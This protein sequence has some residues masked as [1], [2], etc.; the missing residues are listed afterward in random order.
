MRWM[1]RLNCSSVV[2]FD[3]CIFGCPK[4]KPTTLLLIRLPRLR[5]FILSQGNRGRCPHESGTRVALQGC[6]DQG[7]FKTSVAKIY[8][9]KMNAAIA[10][11]TVQFLHRTFDLPRQTEALSED[12][13][14]LMRSDFVSKAVVQPDCYLD[15]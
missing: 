15:V 1:R 2:T 9:A 13:V 5:D 6:D 12:L 10:D 8:P 7:G 14:G 11:A 3:Q 4:R